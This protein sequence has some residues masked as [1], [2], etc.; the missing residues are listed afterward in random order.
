MP[1]TITDGSD[2]IVEVTDDGTIVAE[3]DHGGSVELTAEEVQL[4]IDN[5]KSS[6]ERATVTDGT[7]AV[8]EDKDVFG[9]VHFVSEGATIDGLLVDGE[10]YV[11]VLVEDLS[12]AVEVARAAEVAES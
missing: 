10:H 11:S 3:A 1:E 6:D 9:D 7:D 4:A 8:T 5:A 2:Y 12:D